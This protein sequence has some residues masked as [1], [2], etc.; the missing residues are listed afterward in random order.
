M[1]SN[2]DA[3]SGAQWLTCAMLCAWCMLGA[4]T[5]PLLLLWEELGLAPPGCCIMGLTA[6]MLAAPYLIGGVSS[7]LKVHTRR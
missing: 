7:L 6:A 1:N 5:R 4:A 2:S 3:G